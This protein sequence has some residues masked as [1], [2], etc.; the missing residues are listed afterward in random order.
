MRLKEVMFH[1][2]NLEKIVYSVYKIIIFIRCFTFI[3]IEIYY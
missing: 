2:S 3:S 1:K